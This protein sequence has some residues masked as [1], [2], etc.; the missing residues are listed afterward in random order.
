MANFVLPH[1][2][3]Y[4]RHLDEEKRRRE[5]KEWLEQ[6]RCEV[7]VVYPSIVPQMQ[8]RRR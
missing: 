2:P 4:V 3:N 1:E 5:I 8:D 6:L 7:S